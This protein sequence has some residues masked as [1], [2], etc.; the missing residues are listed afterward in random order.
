MRNLHNIEKSG[1]RHGEYVGYGA[2][3]TWRITRNASAW[4]AHVRTGD[5]APR[6]SARTL[7]ELSTDLDDLDAAY[8]RA[9]RAAF[10]ADNT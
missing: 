10:V 2:G 4:H 8:L 1:F 6:L 7:T 5:P 3:R 9:R